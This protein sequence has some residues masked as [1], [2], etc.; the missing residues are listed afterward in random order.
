MYCVKCGREGSAGEKRCP[1]CGTRLVTPAKLKSLLELEKFTKSTFTGRMDMRYK[2]IKKR[3]R[4]RA[5]RI[6]NWL[7]R[8]FSRLGSAL[9]TFFGKLSVDLAALFTLIGRLLWQLCKAAGKG[10]RIAAVFTAKY[11]VIGVKRL[12]AWIKRKSADIKRQYEQEK[13][14]RQAQQG[15]RSQR[16]P[17]G[18]APA[19]KSP[20]SRS[21]EEESW[22]IE[23]PSP[24]RASGGKVVRPNRARLTGAEPSQRRT[25][26]SRRAMA[27]RPSSG[28]P[29][30]NAKAKKR[31]KPRPF[32][33]DWAIKHARSL[34]AMGLL[35][36]ALISFLFW[37]EFSDSGQKTFAQVGLGNARGYMLIGDDYMSRQNYS[38]AVEY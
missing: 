6:F 20:P 23:E 1:G 34:V 11:A 26:D 2:R 13:A 29:V 24:A 28:R 5:A 4:R 17:Q 10:I 9:K 16:P 22:W 12:A 30:Q 36:L 15:A 33:R 32:T 19:R 7:G 35:A 21:S 8:A 25:S 37:G 38:R 18:S 3:V 27:G 31:K 14:F